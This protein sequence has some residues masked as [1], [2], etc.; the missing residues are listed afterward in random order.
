MMVKPPNWEES[1]QRGGHL[2]CGLA[3]Y[4]FGSFLF[5]SALRVSFML[6]FGLFWPS[7]WRGE[8]LYFLFFLVLSC[9]VLYYSFLSPFFCGVILRGVATPHANGVG[10]VD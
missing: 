2:S 5:G 3:F 10:V 9:L 6:L 1:P 7:L 4:Y 8:E